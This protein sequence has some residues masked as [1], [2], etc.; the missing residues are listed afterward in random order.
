MT[1]LAQGKVEEKVFHPFDRFAQF[2]LSKGKTLGQ[3]LDEFERLRNQNID[4]LLKL[5]LSEK[6]WNKQ[7]THPGP[8]SCQSEATPFHLGCPRPWSHP[9]NDKGYGSP[10]QG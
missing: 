1:V 7:A 5:E 4:K 3:L 6:D 9:P 2:E 8:G 10:I